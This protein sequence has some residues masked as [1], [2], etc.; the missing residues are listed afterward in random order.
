M[1]IHRTIF[2][3]VGLFDENLPACED[4]DLWTSVRQL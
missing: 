2:D 3:D 1:M 4:Y